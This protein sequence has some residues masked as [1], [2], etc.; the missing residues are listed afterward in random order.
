M[1]ETTLT[2][3]F[4][5]ID[6]DSLKFFTIRDSYHKIVYDQRNASMAPGKVK[7]AISHFMEQNKGVYNIAFRKEAV[8]Q[9]KAGNLYE[10]TLPT[11]SQVSPGDMGMQGI[12]SPLFVMLQ[13]A[14]K[15]LNNSNMAQMEMLIKASNAS[16]GHEI[17]ILKLKTEMEKG[18]GNKELQRL[19]V[20]TLSGFFGTDVNISGMG[21]E[22]I[23]I[24]G[25]DEDKINEAVTGLCSHDP[26][27]SKHIFKLYKL[28]ETEPD[29]YAFIIKKLN[30]L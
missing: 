8:P 17:E 26:Q 23:S 20:S 3:I 14:Q 10:Y 16:H 25:L 4:K 19:A 13:Q 27:F 7:D 5:M 29:T 18:G 24:E 11:M 15:D 2:Y 1:N 21:D 30:Q 12:N 9:G 28:S 6:K 22:P